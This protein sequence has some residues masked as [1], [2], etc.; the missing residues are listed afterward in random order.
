MR[1]KDVDPPLVLPPGDPGQS[2]RAVLT[3]VFGLQAFRPGQE[4]VIDTLL[5]GRD[6]LAVMPTG[7]GK[8]LCFQLPALVLG[9]LTVVISPL[10]ALMENQVAALKLAGIAA[11]TIH[12]QRDRAANVA[13]WRSVVAGAVRL[14]YLS[15]ERLM[16]EPM[17]AAL[18]R[19]PLRLIAIDE[20]HCISQWGPSFRPEYEDLRRLR[21]LFP[22]AVIAAF[23][24]TAD[25]ATRLD[26]QEKLFAGAARLFVTGFDRP[27]IRLAVEPKRDWKRQLELFVRQH[28]AESGIVYCL[29]RSKTEEAAQ[30]LT[31]KGVRALPYHAGMDKG[32]RLDNQ[33]AFLTEP[34]IVMAATIAFG[35]GIDK[36]DVRFVFHTDIPGSLEAYY[37]EIGR[38]G[39]DGLPA[40][41]CMLYGLD[42]IRMRRRFIEEQDTAGDHQR[43]EHARLN[44]LIGYCESPSCRRGTL[45]AYFGE[46]MRACGGCDVCLDPIELV[47]GT[48]EARKVLSAVARTGERYGA[49]HIVDVLLGKASEKIRA[50]GHH[51]LPTFGVGAEHARP[52]WGSIIRQMVAAG[53][54]RLD[55]QG[56]SGL[57]ITGEGRALLK[58]NGDFRFRPDPVRGRSL[59]K[60]SAGGSAR[61]HRAP[62]DGG[63]LDRNLVDVLKRVRLEIARER[64]V[65]AYVV[66]H[67]RSLE[68]MARRRPR[69]ADE[70]ATVFGVGAAKAGDLAEPFLKAIAAYY[71]RATPDQPAPG[72]PFGAVT[73]PGGRPA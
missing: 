9:N 62:A 43:R 49:S 4:E 55:I 34:G 22:G 54:L 71:L 10:V 73:P 14:L 50:A 24:A 59:R 37:Q 20:A 63:E 17:L 5:S 64:G 38:A 23:T 19:L 33:N 30:F 61:T 2:K 6:V 40:E 13:V 67:D 25:E 3:A 66:F 28:E 46:T 18:A 69:T 45:L 31:G 56:F 27:N 1:T 48:V 16:T 11:E 15:P 36:P 39:R 7:S 53:Y 72:P 70:F 29:S 35:M 65:P 12:S 8:S 26:I 41:A 32:E 52:A 58:G 60:R 44:A 42:D 57:S 47:D 21:R 68:D 51:A